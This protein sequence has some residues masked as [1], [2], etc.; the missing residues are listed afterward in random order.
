MEPADWVGVGF[1]MQNS[2]MNNKQTNKHK[3]TA[4]K[5]LTSQIEKEN[6]L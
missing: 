4:I 3:M 2:Q 5:K 6:N 1:G